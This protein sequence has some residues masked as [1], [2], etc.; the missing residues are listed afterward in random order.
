MIDIGRF[1][2]GTVGH[3][4]AERSVYKSQPPRARECFLFGAKDVY[5]RLNSIGK[6]RLLC[7][8]QESKRRC[9]RHA[10]QPNVSG[11]CLGLAKRLPE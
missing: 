6:R 11:Q 2:V 3:K 5:V 4:G 1:D 7:S 10:G 8:V 9:H